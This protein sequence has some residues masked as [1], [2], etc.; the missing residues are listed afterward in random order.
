MGEML[1]AVK[2]SLGR[3]AEDIQTRI[4][5]QIRAF[6]QGAAQSDDITLMVL[7]RDAHESGW[8]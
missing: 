4:L 1:Q 8:F 5:H 2:E 3:E 7:A 6:A